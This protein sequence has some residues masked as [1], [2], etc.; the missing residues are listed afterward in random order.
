MGSS[1][2][3]EISIMIATDIHL[4]YQEQDPVRGTDSFNTFG[5]ILQHAK[6]NNVDMVLLGGDLFHENKPSLYTLNE[7]IKLLREFTVGDKRV[8]FQI[9]SNQEKNFGKRVN[10]SESHSNVD[11]PV[12]SIHG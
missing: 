4:G 2:N 7:A 3:D 9:T 11:L 1:A 6:D 12:F 8:G 5:E 10:Y